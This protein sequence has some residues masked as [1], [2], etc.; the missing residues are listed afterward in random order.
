MLLKRSDDSRSGSRG[1]LMLA[2]PCPVCITVIFFSA[3]FLITCFPDHA[4]GVVFTL[5]LAFVLI[6]LASVGVI[7]LYRKRQAA[8]PESFLGGTMLLMA[9]YLFL[10]VTVMPQF[11]D[12]EKVYQLATHQGQTQT[13]KTQHLG[14]FFLLTAAAFAGGYGFKSKQI[15]SM[16]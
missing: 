11:A 13:Q 9:V 10:S 3:G 8:S 6:S 1:W 15:R 2:L 14:L 12:A 5:Y 7:H 4:K 16:T